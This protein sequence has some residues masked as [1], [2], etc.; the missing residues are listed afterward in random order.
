MENNT[1]YEV[2]VSNL[3]VTTRGKKGREKSLLAGIHFDLEARRFVGVIA[4]YKTCIMLLGLHVLV[5]RVSTWPG[6]LSRAPK[7]HEHVG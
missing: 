3:I 7:L 1:D 6:G 4:P 5:G 2:N